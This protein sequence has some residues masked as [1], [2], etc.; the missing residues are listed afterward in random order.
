MEMA[1][2]SERSELSII[3]LLVLQ[4]HKRVHN[5]RSHILV[6]C[7]KAYLDLILNCLSSH[8]TLI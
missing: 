1:V 2:S 3:I 5:E 7:M 8:N 6:Y 4:T